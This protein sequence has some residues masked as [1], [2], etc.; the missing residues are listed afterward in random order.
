MYQALGYPMLSE[1][2][3]VLQDMQSQ[4]EL[5]SDGHRRHKNKH[6]NQEEKP[7]SDVADDSSGLCDPQVLPIQVRRMWRWLAAKSDGTERRPAESP[8]SVFSAA[9]AAWLLSSY[10]SQGIFAAASEYDEG[11]S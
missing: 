11:T 5:G 3:V 9:E 4:V 8:V 2:G 10:A 7:A 6:K 1:F